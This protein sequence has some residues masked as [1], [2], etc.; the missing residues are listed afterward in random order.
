MMT[1]D[2][3]KISDAYQIK[4]HDLTNKLQ[5]EKETDNK[6]QIRRDKNMLELSSMPTGTPQE[7][8]LL[9]HVKDT[10]VYNEIGKSLKRTDRNSQFNG[11]WR[12]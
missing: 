2:K 8:A 4:M 10:L 3:C 7:E 11:C 12:E 5:C 6:Q 9:R 1:D